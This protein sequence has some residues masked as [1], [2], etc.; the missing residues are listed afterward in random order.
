[1]RNRTLSMLMTCGLALATVLVVPAVTAEDGE[2]PKT[3]EATCKASF[4]P[5]AVETKGEDVAIA[6]ALSEPVGAV[7]EIEIDPE[8]GLTIS[9]M[10]AEDG[11]TLRLEADTTA[12]KSGTWSVW[13]I[14]E[15]GTCAG[16]LTIA[17][18]GLAS[19]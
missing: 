14:G 4:E 18:T 17:G 8:S 15:T 3:D 19:L 16:Q 6:V 5:G 12:A 10:D 9:A 13:V 7:E 11:L 1:M 2:T